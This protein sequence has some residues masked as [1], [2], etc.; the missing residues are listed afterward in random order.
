LIATSLLGNS[1]HGWLGSQEFLKLALNVSK[2][3]FQFDLKVA[4][5]NLE[6]QSTL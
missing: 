5:S 4:P 2:I 6:P 1:R 3:P